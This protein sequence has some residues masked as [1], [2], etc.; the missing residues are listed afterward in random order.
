MV[1]TRYCPFKYRW[2]YASYR[3]RIVGGES[4]NI[5]SSFYKKW[6]SRATVPLNTCECRHRRPRSRREGRRPSLRCWSSRHRWAY[7][8]Y[9]TNQASPKIIVKFFYPEQVFPTKQTS[10]EKNGEKLRRMKTDECILITVMTNVSTKKQTKINKKREK[11]QM[12]RRCK[13]HRLCEA[14]TKYG[15]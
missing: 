14:E 12:A 9:T 8:G 5:N 2:V 4:R 3:P 11:D 1:I 15:K 7:L 13:E 10:N 6:W